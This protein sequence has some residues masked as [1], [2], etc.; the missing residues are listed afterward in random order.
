MFRIDR[1]GPQVSQILCF[2]D[3]AYQ[4]Q[5][6]HFLLMQDIMQDVLAQQP[7]IREV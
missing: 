5:A 4:L 6:T 1:Q 7:K 3:H 2:V